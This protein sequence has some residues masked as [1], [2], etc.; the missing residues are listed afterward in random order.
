MPPGS[1]L[2]ID[3]LPYAG[4]L[5]YFS[6]VSEE[7][8]HQIAALLDGPASGGDTVAR[9]D[10]ASNR[11]RY[12]RLAVL[13]RPAASL[14]PRELGLLTAYGSLAAAALDAA[15]ALEDARREATVARI[16]LELSSALTTLGSPDEVAERV[17]SAAPALIG[18]DRSVV[19]F[20][21]EAGVRSDR[22]ARWLWTGR[23][24]E[25]AR[26]E[27]FVPGSR[28]RPVDDQRPPTAPIAGHL[29]ARP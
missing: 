4:E 10:V 19:T 3:P 22:G 29:T 27:C 24:N 5:V 28:K 14:L 18:C 2:A 13:G 8:A 25:T 23:D 7:E 15:A 26:L 21:R 17:A 1:C 9:I 20:V 6:G 12:G 11:R 16:L